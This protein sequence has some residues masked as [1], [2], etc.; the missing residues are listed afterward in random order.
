MGE[1]D[2]VLGCGFDL[3][4]V[5]V[6]NCVKILAVEAHNL[7]ATVASLE[8]K[9]SS[10][11]C[12]LQHILKI[13]SSSESEDSPTEVDNFWYFFSCEPTVLPK[14][15]DILLDVNDEISD[16]DFFERSLSAWDYGE[17][18][19]I[20]PEPLAHLDPASGLASKSPVVSDQ[21]SDAR[22]K[23]NMPDVVS[24]PAETFPVKTCKKNMPDVVSNPTETILVKKCKG[25]G[26]TNAVLHFLHNIVQ[27]NASMNKTNGDNNDGYFHFLP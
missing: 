15:N 26:V 27:A 14:L 23:K 9:A 24:N 17:V 21:G 5:S 7:H 8:K 10:V 25:N 1:S 2:A 4:P 3:P 16:L 20:F 13:L 22:C 18:D 6:L 12:G 11:N 19:S